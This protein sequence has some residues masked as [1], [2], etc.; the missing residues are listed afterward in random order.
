MIA[1]MCFF[2]G[3]KKSDPLNVCSGKKI[4]VK[5]FFCDRCYAAYDHIEE[6]K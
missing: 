1:L 6:L 4:S 5:R 3:H 2:I